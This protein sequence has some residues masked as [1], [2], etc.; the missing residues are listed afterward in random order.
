MSWLG[1]ER[2]LNE[3]A[4][5]SRH[6]LVQVVHLESGD[7]SEEGKDTSAGGRVC[8]VGGTG[9]RR[10]RAR[11]TRGGAGHRGARASRVDWCWCGTV[12]RGVDWSDGSN[13][14]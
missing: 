5:L 14:A 7:E 10:D 2:R 13:R 1:L 12:A 3:C 6:L 4:R 9:V 8:L 11:G